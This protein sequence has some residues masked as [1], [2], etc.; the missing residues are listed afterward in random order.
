M[1]ICI[2]ESMSCGGADWTPNNMLFLSMN[3]QLHYLAHLPLI[4]DTE[5]V[6]CIFNT[7]SIFTQLITKRRLA[8]LQLLRKLYITN[9]KFINFCLVSFMFLKYTLSVKFAYMCVRVCVCVC[10][11]ARACTSVNV[12]PIST[13]SVQYLFYV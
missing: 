5:T 9:N 8:N 4:M 2:P 12:H 13:V 3:M 1:C 6:T 7:N 10:A 11:R